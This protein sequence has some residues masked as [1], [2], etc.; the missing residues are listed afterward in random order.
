MVD[1]PPYHSKSDPVERCWGVLERHGNG[2]ELDS[3][4]AVLRWAGTMTWRGVRPL[5]RE[6][7]LT[8]DRGVRVG[9]AAFVAVA[10]R[11]TRSETLPKWSV[12]IRPG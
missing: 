10:E 9:K 4:G 8:D 1:L 12:V 11:L 5:V 6:V 2:T 7:T 3:V